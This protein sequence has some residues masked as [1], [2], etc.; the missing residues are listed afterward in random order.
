MASGRDFVLSTKNSEASYRGADEVMLLYI[1]GLYPQF[2]PCLYITALHEQ[3]YAKI[4]SVL[5]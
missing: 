5:S 1:A 3:V 4:S 2:R